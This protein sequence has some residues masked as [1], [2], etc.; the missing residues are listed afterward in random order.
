MTKPKGKKRK[1]PKVFAVQVIILLTVMYMAGNYVGNRFRL[2][3]DD[4]MAPCLPFKYYIIDM[5]DKTIP[6]DGFLAFRSDSRMGPWYEEGTLFIKQVRGIEGDKIEVKEGDVFVN[7]EPAGFFDQN[8]LEKIE[9]APKDLNRDET[10]PPE[11][12]WAMGTSPDSF[13]SRYWGYIKQEQ[14]A[15]QVYPLF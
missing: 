9:K 10:V 6:R 13:D 11:A 5:A 15:G 8:I 1:D 4:Q 7:G 12:I 3:I 14:V 2:G